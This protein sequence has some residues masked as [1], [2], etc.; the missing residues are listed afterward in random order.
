MCREIRCAV[1][2]SGPWSHGKPNA[3][4]R[5]AGFE[6]ATTCTRIPVLIWHTKVGRPSRSSGR[7]VEHESPEKAP[8]FSAKGLASHRRRPSGGRIRAVCLLVG[9]WQ[10]APSSLALCGHCGSQVAGQE[11]GGADRRQPALVP[12]GV[13]EPRRGIPRHPEVMRIATS[14]LRRAAE[15]ARSVSAVDP[16]GDPRGTKSPSV[17]YRRWRDWRC[18]HEL[19]VRASRSRP[20]TCALRPAPG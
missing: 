8:R 7:P 15:S 3:L 18:A 16:Q 20:L 5:V 11:T 1:Y 19:D 9:E 6:L 14:S 13:G 4:V 12:S 2:P 17:E 10:G